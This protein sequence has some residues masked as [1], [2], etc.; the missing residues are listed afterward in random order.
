MFRT[1][2][3][4]LNLLMI[5]ASEEVMLSLIEFKRLPCLLYVSQVNELYVL[6]T[7]FQKIDSMKLVCNSLV[8]SYRQ[9]MMTSLMNSLSVI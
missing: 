6:L 8:M 4:E 5:N 9:L 2:S 7:L 3:L 1:A